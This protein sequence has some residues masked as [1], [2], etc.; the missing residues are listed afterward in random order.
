M[1]DRTIV[2]VADPTFG[3]GLILLPYDPLIYVIILTFF[4]SWVFC[5]SGNLL[6]F[7]VGASVD[8]DVPR[9]FWGRLEGKYGNMFYWK[10]KVSLMHSQ[11]ESICLF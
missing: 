7:N 9:S 4:F 6:N 10:E 2:F 11:S 1:D 3:K 8:I 5:I